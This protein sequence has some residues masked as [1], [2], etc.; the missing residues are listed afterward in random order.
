MSPNTD[1][2]ENDRDQELQNK[3]RDQKQQDRDRDLDEQKMNNDSHKID[4]GNPERLRDKDHKMNKRINDVQ[5]EVSYDENTRQGNQDS[6]LKKESQWKTI[7][8]DYRKKYPNL[9][10]DDVHYKI[11]EFDIMIGRIAKRTSRNHEEVN[12]EIKDWNS[13]I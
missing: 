11:G 4:L 7:K 8:A 5:G 3:D 10:D 1:N 13:T 9:T 2:R 6:H 12:S